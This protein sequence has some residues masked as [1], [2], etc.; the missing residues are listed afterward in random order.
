[1]TPR[2]LLDAATPRPW[3]VVGLPWNNGEPW[4]QAESEDPHAGRYVCEFDSGSIADMDQENLDADAALIVAAVNEYEALNE[5]AE[6][7]EPMVEPF[8]VA[9]LDEI[10]TMRAALARLSA[11]RTETKPPVAGSDAP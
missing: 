6:A 8:H 3:Y 11:V 4:I 1:M 2:D 7:A 9:T 5:V 10:R